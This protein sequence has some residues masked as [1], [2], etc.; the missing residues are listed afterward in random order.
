MDVAFIALLFMTA[1]TG[2]ALLAFRETTA[3]GMLPVV[4]LG[5][6]L[7]LFLLLPY[8]KFVHGIYRLAALIRYAVEQRKGQAI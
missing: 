1:V 7:A 8:S 4:H 3:M 6:V 2:L 5:F